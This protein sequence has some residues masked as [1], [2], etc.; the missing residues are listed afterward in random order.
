MT[1][2]FDQAE[3]KMDIFDRLVEEKQYSPEAFPQLQP[4][5]TTEVAGELLPIALDIAGGIV[6]PQLAIPHGAGTAAK[7]MMKGVNLFS[8]MA[9]SAAGGGGGEYAKQLITGQKLEPEKAGKQALIGA[10]AELGFVPIGLGAKAL[11][12][13]LFPLFHKITFSGQVLGKHLSNKLVDKTIR[14][15]NDFLYDV[16]P[17][18]IKKQTVD[19]DDIVL[20]MGKAKEEISA[21]YEQ[22]K[23]P[24]REAAEKEEGRVLIDD[25]EQFLGNLMAKLTTDNP[26]KKPAALANELMREF[27]YSPNGPYARELK[28]LILKGEHPSDKT[29]F[30]LLD[31]VFRE[32]P[33][34]KGTFLKQSPAIKAQREQLKAMLLADME[35]L[36]G[37]EQKGFA[38]KMFIEFKD[39]EFLKKLYDRAIADRGQGIKEIDPY[40]MATTIHMFKDDILKI[41]EKRAKAGLEALWP[42]LEEEAKFFADLVPSFQQAKASYGIRPG[43]MGT[44]GSMANALA[45]A[46]TGAGSMY[47]AYK[48]FGPMGIPVIEGFGAISAYSLLSPT[49]KKAIQ[50]AARHVT[51]SAIK[52]GMHLGNEYI[53]F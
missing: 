50:I 42:K 20:K 45:S 1:D 5:P 38:D 14:R 39:F 16:A 36:A 12:K 34:G 28:N 4:K 3:K 27:G 17:Q 40:K 29:F 8:R 53:E 24:V 33:M 26:G 48:L 51:K 44:A 43:M 30:F 41:D 2:I 18:S 52:T 37:V 47:G 23:A 22:Y 25:T 31:N 46:G 11:A 6:A 15:A 21:M 7:L 10:G 9:G 32:R 49:G 19:I 13:P 35:K